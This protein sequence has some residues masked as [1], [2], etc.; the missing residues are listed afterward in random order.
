MLATRSID[1]QYSQLVSYEHSLNHRDQGLKSAEMLAVIKVLTER[2]KLA[3]GHLDVGTFTARYVLGLRRWVAGI[4][5]G[6][7]IVGVDNN[8]TCVSFAKSR[9]REMANDELRIHIIKQDFLKLRSLDI[10]KF[11]LITVML[12]TLSHFGYDKNDRHDD[13]LQHALENM[14]DLLSEDGILVLSNWSEQ[15]CATRD[16]LGIYD[17]AERAC[18]AS[19]TANTWELDER[20]HR[21]GL[22]ILKEIPVEDRLKISI[23]G[24]SDGN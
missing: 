23:C 24:Y 22:S 20:L 7:R 2:G 15:A 14:A 13:T 21:V 6:G 8:Q 1:Y 11:D 19:W 9:V 5:E 4:E 18:L 12:G 17:D 16:M 10:G 3:K